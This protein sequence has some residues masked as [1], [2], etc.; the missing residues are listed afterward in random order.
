MTETDISAARD[1]IRPNVAFA[2]DVLADDK[3]LAAR[4]GNR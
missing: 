1:F 2:I 3:K 4:D